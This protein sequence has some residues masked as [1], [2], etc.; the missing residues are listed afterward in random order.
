[1]KFYDVSVDIHPKMQVYPG[2]PR[3]RSKSIRSLEKGDSFELSKIMMSNHIG[4][5]VDAPSHLIS[6]GLT[7]TD[8]PLEVMNGRVRVIH[9]SHR[10]KVD[11]PELK[12][13][14]LMNDV[15]IL[16]KTR[17]SGLW[18][19]HKYFSKKYIYLTPD[20]ARYLI[21]N[22]IKLVGF[23]YHSVDRLTDQDYPVH[24]V[25]LQN[26][27]ILVEGLNLSAVDDGIYDM[28]CLPLKLKGM[29]AAPAR[30]VL[31]K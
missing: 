23:D 10:E 5:H 22:G 7:I 6:G 30:V 18:T 3:F 21:D 8:I 31:K 28:S 24:K 14:T 12:Q 13:L 9:S 27:V 11:V 15:R 17:N 25:L 16:F 19:D 2:D 26:Q 20:A 29:D 4:T 1:M